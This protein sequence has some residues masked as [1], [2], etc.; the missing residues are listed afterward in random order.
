MPASLVICQLCLTRRARH[1]DGSTPAGW[2]QS[3]TNP[4]LCLCPDCQE[5]I[6]AA[7]QEGRFIIL[8]PDEVPGA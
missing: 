6:L 2:Y 7:V 1:E 4:E 8:P 3:P 5:G